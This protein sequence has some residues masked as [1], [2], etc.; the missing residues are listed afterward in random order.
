MATHSRDYL[1]R[2][3]DTA[4]KLTSFHLDGLTT[5][6][7]LWRPASAGPHVHQLPSGD[8]RADWPE[9]ER[10]DLGP[11]SIAWITWHIGFWWSMALD[12]SF[13]DRTLSRETVTWPGSADAVREWVAGLQGAWREQLE[14]LT[15]ADLQSPER[16]RWPFRDRPFGDVIAWVNIELT[17]NAAEIGYGRFLH[18]VRTT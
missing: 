7:C 1:V 15:D 14:H 9:H 17:K 8:W 10:Y 4:W 3:L 18:A 2:Q 13:G 11:P 6:E 12:H 16:T 5:E